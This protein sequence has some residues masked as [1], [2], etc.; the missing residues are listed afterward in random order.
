MWSSVATIT[1]SSTAASVVDENNYGLM[2]IAAVEVDPEVDI[3]P[4]T[5]HTLKWEMHLN[6]YFD[7]YDDGVYAV[8]S[9]TTAHEFGH[10]IG[11]TDL[12]LSQ[13]YNKLMCGYRDRR[14]ATAPTSRDLWGAQV[15][16]GLHNTHTFTS[17]R[18]YGIIG[19]DGYHMSCCS[20]CGGNAIG[21]EPC[22]YR[23]DNS[24]EPCIYCGT[25]RT[26]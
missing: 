25:N 18:Y 15:I 21:R 10:T 9:V 5:G 3:N 26:Y 4:E 7:F 17:Y 13:N 20:G 22:V 6:W 2:F 24:F 11:L 23:T 14:T 8:N 19:E 16:L 12:Y 1:E